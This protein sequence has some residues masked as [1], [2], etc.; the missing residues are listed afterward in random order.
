MKL[1][2]IRG[3]KNH[4]EYLFAPFHANETVT[5]VWLFFTSDFGP[6]DFFSSNKLD[7]TQC[8]PEFLRLVFFFVMLNV[9][10]SFSPDV[11]VCFIPI[12]GWH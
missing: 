3:K 12:P 4:E 7:P 2:E 1:L 5:K 6:K 9:E 10:V 11:T 8:F